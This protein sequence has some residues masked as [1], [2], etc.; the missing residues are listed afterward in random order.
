MTKIILSK[1]ALRDLDDLWFY[2][3]TDIPQNAD[4]FLDR[5]VAS[6]EST[7]TTLPLA[8]RPREEFGQGLRSFMF[9]N[10]VVFYRKLRRD[11]QVVRIIHGRR[12]LSNVFQTSR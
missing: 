10:Y 8:G 2:I 4:R 1:E 11:I 12:D 7:L 9:E 3:A 5:L 6:I